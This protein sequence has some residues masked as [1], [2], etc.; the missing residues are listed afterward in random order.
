MGIL[1]QPVG[2]KSV[3]WLGVLHQ[4]QTIFTGSPHSYQSV[5]TNEGEAFLLTTPRTAP[6]SVSKPLAASTH[7]TCSSERNNIHGLCDVRPPRRD[8][9]TAL[10]TCSSVKESRERSLS[11]LSP[12]ILLIT[13][14]TEIQI[15]RKGS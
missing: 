8:V 3:R 7:L 1:I 11:T 15:Y 9:S 6:G 12:C 4:A 13:Y 2:L 5:V 14:N 10:N